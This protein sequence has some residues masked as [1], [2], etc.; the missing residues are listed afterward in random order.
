MIL[1]ILGFFAGLAGL[2]LISPVVVN[3]SVKLGEILRVSP[4]LIGIIAI[5]VGTSMPEITN[6][7]VS[8]VMGYSNIGI[9]NMIGSSMTMFTLGAGLLLLIRGAATFDRK[10]VIVLSVCSMLGVLLAY[11]IIEK[12]SISRVNGIILIFVYFALY[13]LMNKR[14][15]SKEYVQET[16][17]IVIFA[18]KFK[19]A[20]ILL[21]SLAGVILSSVVFI[22]SVV[23]LSDIFNVP[24][25]LISFFLVSIGTSMPEFFVGLSA[26]KKK[27]YDLFVG[28]LFGSVITNLDLGI[29]LGAFFKGSTMNIDLIIPAFNYFIIVLS[30]I[31]VMMIF[32]KKLDRK[33]GLL[34]VI[35]YILSFFIVK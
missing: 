9:G 8:S 13:Y 31:F 7:I 34:L 25:F 3:Y 32:N 35:F 33:S 23:T 4:M 5:A 18:K 10:N 28:N 22:N 27:E 20:F 17:T 6:S 26:L 11:S 14:M 1:S 15:V 21:I 24:R 12:G 16:T 19:Y 29:G 30:M 2:L